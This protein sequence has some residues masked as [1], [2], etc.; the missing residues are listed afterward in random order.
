MGRP[1]GSTRAGVGALP[2]GVA[3]GAPSGFLLAFTILGPPTAAV[4]VRRGLL[5]ALVP[6]AATGDMSAGSAI[7]GGGG[8]VSGAGG[9]LPLRLRDLMLFALMVS[10]SELEELSLWAFVR[11][12]LSIST[13]CS[14]GPSDFSASEFSVSPPTPLETPSSHFRILLRFSPQFL[15]LFSG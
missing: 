14:G 11:T 1:N 2:V 10:E 3:G 9:A 8:I 13:K 12:C 6:E 7:G 5:D 15:Q 4:G